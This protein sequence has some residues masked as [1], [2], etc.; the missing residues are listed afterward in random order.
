MDLRPP[1][2]AEDLFALFARAEYQAIG[3]PPEKGVFG[4]LVVEPLLQC[5][6]RAMAAA[7][8]VLPA[9]ASLAVQDKIYGSLE[10]GRPEHPFDPG[11]APLREAAALAAEAERRTG[12]RAALACLLAHAPIDPDWLHLNPVM[13]RHALKG[14]RAARGA[15]CRPRLVNAVDAFGLDMLSSL[16]EGGYAGFMTRVHLGFLRVTGARPWPGRVLTA[17]DGWPRIGGRILRLLAEGGELI[18]VLAG[19]VPVTARGYYALREA[20]GR[21]CRE[22]PAAGRPASVLARLAAND[23]SFTAFLASGEG[24]VLRS[25]WRRIEAWVL[26]RALAPGGRA[27]LAEGRLCPEGAAAFAAATVALGLPVEAAAAAR[28][29]LDAELAR[30]T[31]FRVRFLSAVAGR[32]VSRGRPVVLLP[33]GWGRAGAVRVAF[34]SPVCLLPAPR[35]TVLVLEPSGRTEE[36]DCAAFARAFVEARFP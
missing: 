2:T 36:L 34:G 32:V 5:V 24:C 13:F 9:G 29:E 28:A 23:P 31:P 3:L 17:A 20:T 35:G 11:A 22:S 16:D 27:A 30:E 14:L 1:G 18:M 26:S 8:S 12:R 4:R 7:E 33:L 6:G 10:G 19:G 25:A 21:L 15:A